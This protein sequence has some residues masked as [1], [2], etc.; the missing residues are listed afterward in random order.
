MRAPEQQEASIMSWTKNEEG[1]ER[2]Q[3]QTHRVSRFP[4]ISSPRLS[5]SSHTVS[6]DDSEA[7]HLNEP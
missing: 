6:L 3:A 5:P 4:T 2:K 7:E 1:K